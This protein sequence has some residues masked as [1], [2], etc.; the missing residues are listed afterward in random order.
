MIPVLINQCNEWQSYASFSLVGVF[1]NKIKM[2]K[3]IRT[4]RD[5]GDVKFEKNYEGNMEQATINEL[6]NSFTYLNFKEL[7]FNEDFS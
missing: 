2:C 4:L 6:Q 3:V 5:N 7:N 1:T